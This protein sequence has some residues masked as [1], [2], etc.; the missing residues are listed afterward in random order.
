MELYSRA[1]PALTVRAGTRHTERLAARLREARWHFAPDG[2]LDVTG[3]SFAYAGRYRAADPQTL[4]F[5]VISDSG[6]TMAG[7]LAAD[8]AGGTW[9]AELTYH[10]SGDTGDHTVDVRH[11]LGPPPPGAGAGQEIGGIRVPAAYRVA[12]TGHTGGAAFGPIELD[13][14][15]ARL[16]APD[17]RFALDLTIGGEDLFRIGELTWIASAIGGDAGDGGRYSVTAAGGE[18]VA[19]ADAP[20]G[21]LA[22][23]FTTRNPAPPGLSA[24]PVLGATPVYATTAVIRLRFAGSRVTG[25]ATATG[26]LPLGGTTRYEATLSGTATPG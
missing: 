8:P 6:A 5:S 24:F 2:R 18:L 13:L 3:P 10:A 4:M 1:E 12:L 14:S 17:P 9:S 15:V 7:R 11:R 26:L 16:P 20:A 21:T 25:E 22:V 19:R 23:T